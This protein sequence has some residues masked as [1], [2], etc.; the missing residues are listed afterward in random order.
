MPDSFK[1]LILCSVLTLTSVL[2]ATPALAEGEVNIYSARK[3]DLIKPL[4]DDFSK[5]AGVTVNLVTG[6]EEALLQR[7]QSEGVNTPADLMLTTDAG[8]LAAAREVGV[9]QAV[10]SETLAAR[11][12]A[13]YRDPDGYWYGL[14]VRARPIIYAR[15]RVKPAELSTYDDLAD[16]KWKGK[17]C[18][19]SSDSVYNQSLVAG[20]ISHHGEAKTEAWAKGLVA[21]FAR[22]PKGGD[23]DQ[24]KAVAAGECD[25]TLANTYYLGGMVNSSDEAEKQA[26]AKVAVFWPDAKTAGV[27]V[28]IS[29]AGVT[30]NARNRD[31]AIKLLE[32][33][34][35]DA[36]QRWYAET[37]NEYPVNP[38]IAPSATLKAWG[39]FKADTLNV[40][41]L[42][43]LN[44]AAVR[45]M[46]RAGWK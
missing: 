8:R 23:R 16:P 17:V 44:P 3:E 38:A 4:L 18:V 29:G 21:N 40:A 26:A 27:H 39:E 5:Q 28:N 7:L 22:P 33:M 25:V 45:L 14:S 36:A 32:F 24:I 13:A 31:N 41:K 46:D 43:E 42:G 12:P 30:A 15:E 11:I 34:A 20:M 35:A 9:L 19:R 10:K 6:K 1:P 37:N 2:L